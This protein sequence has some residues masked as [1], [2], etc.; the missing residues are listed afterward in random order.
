MILLKIVWPAT[1][2]SLPVLVIVLAIFVEE[3]LKLLDLGVAIVILAITAPPQLYSNA[4][5]AT[6]AC[7]NLWTGSRIVSTLNAINDRSVVGGSCSSV[8]S[9][10][11]SKRFALCAW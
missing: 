6:M 3:G 7:I 5:N 9:P 4:Q 10:L 1:M 8:F 11:V 2:E